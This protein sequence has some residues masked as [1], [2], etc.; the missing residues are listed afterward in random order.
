MISTCFVTVLADRHD[1]GTL[2]DWGAGRSAIPSRATG[3]VLNYSNRTSAGCAD[4]EGQRPGTTIHEGSRVRPAL[5]ATLLLHPMS[6]HMV[7]TPTEA[8]RGFLAGKSVI[9]AP[10]AY[11]NWVMA[12]ARPRLRNSADRRFAD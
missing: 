6:W 2:S 8:L 10:D 7:I 12:P 3:F 11:D 4:R 5:S 9:A 1:A